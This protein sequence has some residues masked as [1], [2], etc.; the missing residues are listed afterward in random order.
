MRSLKPPPV[1]GL[2]HCDPESH[3]LLARGCGPGADYVAMRTDFDGVPWL[4]FGVPRIQAVMMVGERNKEFG[5]RVFIPLNQFFGFPVEQR[6]LRTKILVSERGRRTIMFQLKLIFVGTLHVHVSR[7][8][9]ARFRNALRTPVRPDTELRIPV[10]LRG[11]ILH[12]GI[13]SWLVRTLA[14]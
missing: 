8:P 6:P 12:E 7:I 3:V 2:V 1:A 5:S 14:A 11:V 13:P 10:P 9:V 4:M